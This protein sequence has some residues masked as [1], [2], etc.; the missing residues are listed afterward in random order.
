MANQE[1]SRKSKGQSDRLSRQHLRAGGVTGIFGTRAR[2]FDGQIKPVIEKVV[3]QLR[4]EFPG[5][6]FRTRSSIPKKEIHQ[7]L[8][9]IDPRLGVKL[10]VSTASIRPD[11]KVTEVQDSRGEW[12][13]VLIG[14]CKFQGKDVQNVPK[15]IRTEKMAEKGQRIMPAGNAIERVHKNIQEFKNLM[16]DER[17]FPYVVFLQ[18]SNFSTERI[19]LQWPDGTAVVIDP[20]D[21]MVS[22]IDRVTASNYGM[23]INTNYCE[24]LIVAQDDK[25]FMLQVASIY[26][27]AHKF[28]SER[29][30]EVLWE[31]AVTSLA[32]LGDDL[33]NAAG[34]D[35]D[36]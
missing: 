9:A 15:G 29:M 7:T 24:N 32:V 10:F 17:H 5:L 31:T 27:D 2:E 6:T 25:S 14:E 35:S 28:E 4:V 11:G 36:G 12:R 3:E 33:P 18:G 23:K 26:A 19:E 21:S 30:F 1:Q 16:L 8:N 13:I 20:S 22:R 34:T